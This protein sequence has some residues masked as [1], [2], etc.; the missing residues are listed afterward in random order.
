MQ[1]LNII[2][3]SL[4]EFWTGITWN[5]LW[6]GMCDPCIECFM[7]KQYNLKPLFLQKCL[8]VQIWVWLLH[9]KI[10]SHYLPSHSG[11]SLHWALLLCCII[12]LALNLFCLPVSIYLPYK[13]KLRRLLP[14]WSCQLTLVCVPAF[15]SCMDV[16]D[17]AFL[18]NCLAWVTK[19]FQSLPSWK[20][21]I[22]HIALVAIIVCKYNSGACDCS[23]VP[24]RQNPTHPEAEKGNKRQQPEQSCVNR[25]QQ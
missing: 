25:W 22:S 24:V 23:S 2:W 17:L 18:G 9:I 10:L 21:P 14:I 4:M 7:C 13:G 11:A 16:Y 3:S 5:Q 6:N 19:Y 15:L 12:A 20:P 1:D 8:Y